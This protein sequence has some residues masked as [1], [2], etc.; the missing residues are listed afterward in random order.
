MNEVLNN[1]FEMFPNVNRYIFPI[2]NEIL[3]II[4]EYLSL[5]LDK[6]DKYFVSIDFEKYNLILNPFAPGS[7]TSIDDSLQY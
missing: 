1:N 7:E 6:F 2:N 3:Q 4:Q 5:L